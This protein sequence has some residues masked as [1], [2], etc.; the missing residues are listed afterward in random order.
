MAAA[1]SSSC[2]TPVAEASLLDFAPQNGIRFFD[3]S[4]KNLP[5]STFV[6]KRID[7]SSLLL[8]K[9]LKRMLQ[10][11]KLDTFVTVLFLGDD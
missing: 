8:L 10:T 2:Q 3:N 5:Y 4:R 9:A 7:A 6:V 11:R 1:G